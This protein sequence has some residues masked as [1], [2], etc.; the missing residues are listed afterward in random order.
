MACGTQLLL[1]KYIDM[2]VQPEVKSLDEIE[3]LNIKELGSGYIS[4]V[5]VGK[6][7]TT[8]KTYAVKIINLSKVGPEET[9]ALRRELNIQKALKHD[10]IVKLHNA[11]ESS[12]FLYIVLEHVGMGNLFEFAKRHE[13][14]EADIVGIFYQVVSAISYLHRQQILHRDIK[15]ENILMMAKDRVKLCDFGFCAPYGGDVVR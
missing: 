2:S 12:G 11:F 5:K 4:K 3:V 6:H 7:R 8:G 14:S 15:P 9:E 1:Y 13:L 10:H